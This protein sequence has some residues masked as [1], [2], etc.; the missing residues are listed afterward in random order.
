MEIYGGYITC[1]I[2]MTGLY[3]GRSSV[4]NILPFIP[5]NPALTQLYIDLYSPLIN[6]VSR[7][8]KGHRRFGNWGPF[9]LGPASPPL[10]LAALS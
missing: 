9:E 1:D 6:L 4:Y 10:P 2:S 5:C 3:D 7:N 8:F